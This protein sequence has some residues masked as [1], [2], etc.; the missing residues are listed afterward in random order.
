MWTHMLALTI[1]NI[2]IVEKDACIE[3]FLQDSAKVASDP[4]EEV[5]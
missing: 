1:L 5:P 2:Y 3:L 4:Y